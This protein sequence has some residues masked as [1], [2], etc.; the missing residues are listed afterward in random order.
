MAGQHAHPLDAALG[1]TQGD[2]QTNGVGADAVLHHVEVGALGGHRRVVGVG[3]DAAL[4]HDQLAAR[5]IDRR[6][7]PG[8]VDVVVHQ[9]H[10]GIPGLHAAGVAAL[11]RRELQAA[12]LDLPHPLGDQHAGLA[13]GRGDHHPGAAGIGGE[14]RDVLGGDHHR[15]VELDGLVAGLAVAADIDHPAVGHIG[16]GVG[17]RVGAIGRV[18]A[19]D[20][21]AG[22]AGLIGQPV[23]V[24]LAVGAA[25]GLDVAAA[26][27]A[28]A[29]V[30]DPL[31]IVM[32]EGRRV[33][34]DAEVRLDLLVD[35]GGHRIGRSGGGGEGPGG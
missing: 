16:G 31:V 15:M 8:V 33:Q 14:G 13:R 4:A 1:R 29:A 9:G 30:P 6:G 10:L 32:P 18:A 17:D 20:G 28:A 26:P 5:D 23:L 27:A 19:V 35:L 34:Q 2:R 22:G 7:V 11:G 21:D 12:D 25:I 24:A 3:V